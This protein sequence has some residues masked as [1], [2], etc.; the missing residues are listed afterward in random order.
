MNKTFDE[1]FNDF[2]RTPPPP[3]QKKID[4]IS[5]I[6]AKF[7]KLDNEEEMMA[8]IDKQLGEPN[9]VETFEEDGII[10]KKMTWITEEGEFVKLAIDSISPELYNSETPKTLT[11]EEQLVEAERVEDYELAIKLRD[12]IN[13]L[14][15]IEKKD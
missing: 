1:L 6:I 5:D 12:K 14:K 2:M 7:K 10:F 9:R 4:K 3:L 13:H 15:G 11:L 8:E